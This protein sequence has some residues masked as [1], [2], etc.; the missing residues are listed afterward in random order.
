MK[1]HTH[2][3]CRENN[4][5]KHHVNHEIYENMP[6]KFGAIWYLTSTHGH[7]ILNPCFQVM[8]SYYVPL[9]MWNVVIRKSIY[10]AFSCVRR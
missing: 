7:L 8:G 5:C 10:V 2:R 4:F 9:Y 3:N 6:Q 1:C